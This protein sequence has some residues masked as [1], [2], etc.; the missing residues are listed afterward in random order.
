MPGLSNKCVVPMA[1]MALVRVTRNRNE[2]RF[3]FFHVRDVCLIIERACTHWESRPG[4]RVRGA[5]RRQIHAAG[6]DILTVR[7]WIWLA[8]PL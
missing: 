7:T 2:S 5:R 8:L 4:A 3:F 1:V 6:T